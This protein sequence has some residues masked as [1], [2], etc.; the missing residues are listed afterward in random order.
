MIDQDGTMPLLDEDILVVCDVHAVVHWDGKLEEITVAVMAKR[1]KISGLAGRCDLDFGGHH[2]AWRPHTPT[3]CTVSSISDIHTWRGQVKQSRGS[4]RSK[5]ERGFKC[6]HLIGFWLGFSKQVCAN[7]VSK[8]QMP[9]CWWM[10]LAG[11]QNHAGYIKDN[12]VVDNDPM[13]A[14]Y[15]EWRNKTVRE[16]I[17][18][19]QKTHKSY[20]HCWQNRAPEV[21][22]CEVTSPLQGHSQRSQDLRSVCGASM[23]LVLRPITSLAWV[24]HE[25][26]EGVWNSDADWECKIGKWLGLASGL[27]GGGHCFR[28]LPPVSS[29]CW[30]IA[31]TLIARGLL[32]I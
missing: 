26:F 31:A 22:V 4:F 12:L 3:P 15:N 23:R 30:P 7:G 9:I 6:K 1:W 28:I 16:F 29:S 18:I 8:K 19:N 21:D 11:V 27:G 20:S 17:L 13:M 32:A 25:W 5:S 14:Y 24:Q 2:S 10:H